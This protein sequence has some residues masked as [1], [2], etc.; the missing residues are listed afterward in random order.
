MKR[1]AVDMVTSI[2]VMYFVT[3]PVLTIILEML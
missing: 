2:P 3:V 1:L